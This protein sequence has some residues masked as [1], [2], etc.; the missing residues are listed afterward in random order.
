MASITI[1]HRHRLVFIHVHMHVHSEN[2]VAEEPNANEHFFAKPQRDPLVMHSVSR[3]QI[4]KS[5]KQS[6]I[7]YAFTTLCA[8]AER[9]VSAICYR[10]ENARERTR[11]GPGASAPRHSHR[12]ADD[13]HHCGTEL[14]SPRHSNQPAQGHAARLCP[15]SMAYAHGRWRTRVRM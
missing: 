12:E 9:G 4:S 13:Q 5:N 11:N 8:R 14:R 15:R 2:M 6:C 3:A 10:Q 7:S 1:T